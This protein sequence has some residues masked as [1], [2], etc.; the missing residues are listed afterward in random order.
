VNV[1]LAVQLLTAHTA[2]FFIS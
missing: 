1:A 2:S